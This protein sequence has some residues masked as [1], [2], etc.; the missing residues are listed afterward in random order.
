[1]TTDLALRRAELLEMRE[2]ILHAAVDLAEGDQ[3]EG[4]LNTAA[5]DQHLADHATDLLDRELDQSLGENAENVITEIDDALGRIEEG[6]YGTCAV[7]G[8][9][10]PKERLDAVPYAVLCLE[11]K[12]RQEHG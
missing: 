9:T 4:E 1:M 7:C 3:G 8:E 5:G 6:T 12:R 11:D 10:I 2:R